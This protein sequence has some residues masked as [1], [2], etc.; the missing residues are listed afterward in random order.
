MLAI[1]KIVIYCFPNWNLFYL[2]LFILVLSLSNDSRSAFS[3]RDEIRPSDDP[4]F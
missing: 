3:L 1:F 4:L 2:D